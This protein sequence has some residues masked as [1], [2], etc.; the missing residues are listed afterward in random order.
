VVLCHETYAMIFFATTPATSEASAEA[1]S[2]GRY[3]V[4]AFFHVIHLTP[5][6]LIAGYS[7]MK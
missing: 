5:Q 6:F 7:W 1:R 4:H 3:N 2:H